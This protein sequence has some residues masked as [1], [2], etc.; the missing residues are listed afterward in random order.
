MDAQARKQEGLLQKGE[1]VGEYFCQNKIM[2]PMKLQRNCQMR[3]CII[4]KKAPKI[5]FYPWPQA[6]WK[7]SGFLPQVASQCKVEDAA[8]SGNGRMDSTAMRAKDTP[9][10]SNFVL[11]FGGLLFVSLEKMFP[12][13]PNWPSEGWTEHDESSKSS[14]ERRPTGPSGSWGRRLRCEAGGKRSR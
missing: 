12:V 11:N 2:E 1:R 9:K 6:N 4:P 10:K 3:L 14:V 5:I 7:L 8:R 13:A